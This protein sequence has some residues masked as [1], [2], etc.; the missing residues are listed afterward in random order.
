MKET[1]VTLF[2]EKD[3]LSFTIQNKSDD[4]TLFNYF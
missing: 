2:A 4:N 1:I 3:T